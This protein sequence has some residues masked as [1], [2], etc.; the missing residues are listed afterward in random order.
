[1]SASLEAWME[2]QAELDKVLAERDQARADLAQA[3]EDRESWRLGCVAWQGWARRMLQGIQPAGGEWGDEPARQL[4][5]AVVENRERLRYDNERL[6]GVITCAAHQGFELL[7]AERD[8]L[9][10][11]LAD[12]PMNVERIARVAASTWD[13][14]CR[15]VAWHVLNALALAAKLDQPTPTGAPDAE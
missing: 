9:R 13:G 1:M 7:V 11:V 6:Q 12:T 2:R 8:G 5:T 15:V 10:A 4:L 14:G 3:V